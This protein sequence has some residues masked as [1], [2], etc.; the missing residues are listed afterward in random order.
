MRI[1]IQS[2]T[3]NFAIGRHI[4][5]DS[6]QKWYDMLKYGPLITSFRGVYRLLFGIDIVG[7]LVTSYT[8]L[9]YKGIETRK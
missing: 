5:S 9:N 2:N 7:R 8:F 1:L 3:L 6:T 4:F